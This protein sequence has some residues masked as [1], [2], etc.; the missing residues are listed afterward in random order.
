MSCQT[1]ELW[2]ARN[3]K[4]SLVP[5][6]LLGC[7]NEIGRLGTLSRPGFEN[8]FERVDDGQTGVKEKASGIRHPASLNNRPSDSHS[9]PDNTETEQLHICT[10]ELANSHPNEK[11][12]IRKNFTHPYSFALTPGWSLSYLRDYL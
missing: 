7:I 4:A 1:V 6:V 11:F 3:R 9:T 10:L 8:G 12:K 2:H 5:Y